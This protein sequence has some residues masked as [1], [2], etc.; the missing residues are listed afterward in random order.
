[1][2]IP[3]L[4]RFDKGHEETK[5]AAFFHGGFGYTFHHKN[6]D[7][8]IYRKCKCHHSEKCNAALKCLVDGYII[9]SGVHGPGCFRKNGKNVVA[10]ASG[11]DASDMMYQL[12]RVQLLQGYCHCD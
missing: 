9:A 3:S 4:F 5:N 10:H 1:M 7:G 8:S 12:L 11:G 6:K 2:A